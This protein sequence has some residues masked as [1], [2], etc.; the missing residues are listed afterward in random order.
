MYL[1]NENACNGHATVLE[2]DKSVDTLDSLACNQ[3]AFVCN[4]TSTPFYFWT[5]N[6]K[7]HIFSIQ[8]HGQ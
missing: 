2:N 1:L 8:D 4:V 3:N 5:V 6:D 7:W